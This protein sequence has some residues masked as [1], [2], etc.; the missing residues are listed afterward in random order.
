ME[1][2]ETAQEPSVRLY[3]GQA[4]LPRIANPALAPDV[5]NI[6]VYHY[7]G[8][9]FVPSSKGGWYP[10]NEKGAII[11]QEEAPTALGR[12]N[13]RKEAVEAG[14]RYFGDRGSPGGRWT[15]L[16]R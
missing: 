2:T 6:K 13:W 4:Q 7:Q 16:P 10:T 12:P 8:N 3:N 15:H 5:R 1:A 11:E 9:Y 14:N